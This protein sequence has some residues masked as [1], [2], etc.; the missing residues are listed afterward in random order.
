MK[1]LLRNISI[2]ILPFVMMI[3]INEAVR[4]SIKEPPFY[5]M[6][7]ATINS[8][9]KMT[10]KCTWACHEGTRY[11]KDHHVKILR[12]LFSETD[13]LYFRTIQKLRET[14]NYEAANLF[15]LVLLIPLAIWYFF[16]RSLNI[17]DKIRDLKNNK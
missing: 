8:G 14:G 7:L 2:L 3:I 17:Q 10:E 15:F 4:P 9:K 16:I 11:C 12:P 1:K 13:T 6:G 5:N